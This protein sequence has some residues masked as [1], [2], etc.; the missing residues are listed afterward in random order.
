MNEAE[1]W[2]A[3]I[4]KALGARDEDTLA[5]AE[6]VVRERDEAL[7]ASAARAEWETLRGLLRLATEARDQFKAERDATDIKLKNVHA[8]RDSA[9]KARNEA[10]LERNEAQGTLARLRYEFAEARATLLGERDAA[11]KQAADFEVRLSDA[12][13]ERDAARE[14]LAELREP[15]DAL[16]ERQKGPAFWSCIGGDMVRIE[17]KVYRVSCVNSMEGVRTSITLDRGGHILRSRDANTVGWPIKHYDPSTVEITFGDTVRWVPVVAPKSR[18]DLLPADALLM[19]GRVVA[20][21]I[22]LGLDVAA[23]ERWKS[24]GSQYHIAAALRHILAH[25]GGQPI[26]TEDGGR[27]HLAHAG[28][29]ILYALARHM[30]GA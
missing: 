21:G 26:N 25:L 14:R 30:E 10:L 20:A 18:P 27:P 12:L 16:T 1:K 24:K 4:R 22:D 9:T 8:A 3:A 23:P 28:T 19:C 6:R 17:G 29:R 11:N 13:G 15:F 5:A 2:I 7:A